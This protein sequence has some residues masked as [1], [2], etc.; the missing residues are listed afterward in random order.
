MAGQTPYEA[1]DNFRGPLQKALSTINQEAHLWALGT[2]GYSPGQEHAL[3]PNAGE[4][5]ELT[6][7]TSRRMGLSYLFTYRVERAEG[8]RGPWKVRT[9]AYFHALEDETSQEIIAYHWH[10][11]LGSNFSFPHLH[12]G[13]GIGAALGEVH[14]YHIP[15]GRVALEDVL[16]LAITEFGVTP[17][18]ADWED[19]LSEGRAAYEA[20]RSWHG[21]GPGSGPQEPQQAEG[22]QDASDEQV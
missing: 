19:V 9:T 14:K 3:V 13:T 10:P 21:S 4:V 8:E 16:R 11:R 6:T 5:V 15:T 22:S 18:R 1:F 2:N 20:W 17:Q 7:T 12:I